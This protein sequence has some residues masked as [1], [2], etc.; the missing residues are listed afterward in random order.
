M[1]QPQLQSCGVPLGRGS[2]C[3]GPVTAGEQGVRGVLRSAPRR[4]R[5]VA[6]RAARGPVD[7]GRIRGIRTGERLVSE[8]GQREGM[9]SSPKASRYGAVGEVLFS[10]GWRDLLKVGFGEIV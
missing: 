2:R 4:R 5:G 9:R 8:R 3:L 10:C 1:D 7:A 6:G